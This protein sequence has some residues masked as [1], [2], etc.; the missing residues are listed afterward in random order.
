MGYPGLPETRPARRGKPLTGT[1]GHGQGVPEYRFG[2]RDD[3]APEGVFTA[4]Q[5]HGNDVLNV[6]GTP[7]ALSGDQGDAIITQVPGVIVAVRTADCLPILLW[8]KG[9]NP[10]GVIHAGWRG[11]VAGIAARAVIGM[12]QR[13]GLS[14]DSV[15]ARL[16]PCIR[17]CCYEV[18]DEVVDAVRANHPHWADEVF[19]DRNGRPAFDL[20][21]L[22]RIQLTSA[23]VTDV[24]DSG[25]CTHCLSGTYHSYRRDGE[26]AGRMLSWIRA[27]PS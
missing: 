7:P 12:C 20:A 4:R 21:A 14:S 10:V 8:A 3:P 27:N 16:G 17:P 23:G 5:V 19:V 26:A 13:Y 15:S 6:S 22:N 24:D 1:S 9:G 2:S 11:T 25:E 18:G